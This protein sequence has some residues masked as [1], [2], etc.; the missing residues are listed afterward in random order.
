MSSTN[1]NFILLMTIVLG[2]GLVFWIRH[3]YQPTYQEIP[4]T[5]IVGTSADYPPFSFKKDDQI[6]GFDIDVISE[7]VKRLGKQIAIKNSPFELLLPQAGVGALHVVAANLAI[8]PERSQLVLFSAPYL[9]TN[10]LVVLSLAKHPPL[11]SLNDLNDK[12]VA[13]NAGYTADDYISKLPHIAVNRV[14]TI[15]DAVMALNKG[16]VD[17][18]VTNSQA[19]PPLFETFG[20][21]A[22]NVLLINDVNENAA[23]AI[24]KL[25]PKLAHAVNETLAQMQNDGTLEQLKQK[26]SVQ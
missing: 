19:L 10:P 23:L 16:N 11:T 3:L 7:I 14:P 15:A 12:R 24:S 2:L 26:W 1:R 21:D 13:V 4:T 5:I 25:Y 17:A 22:F 8:T 18:V 20:K 9:T 6:V